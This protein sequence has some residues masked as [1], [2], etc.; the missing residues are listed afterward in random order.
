[1]S[2]FPFCILFSLFYFYTFILYVFYIYYYLYYR[3]CFFFLLGGGQHPHSSLH[4]VISQSAGQGLMPFMNGLIFN[5]DSIA[6]FP[7]PLWNLILFFLLFIVYYNIS[8]HTLSIPWWIRAW[9]IVWMIFAFCKVL[10]VWMPWVRYQRDNKEDIRLF[11]NS[12]NHV[13]LVLN[14]I[15]L[16]AFNV[17]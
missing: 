10:E 12:H 3:Y 17:T 7:N 16:C 9:R 15:A 8:S 5:L 11:Q 2:S 14:K 6:I 1:M 13:M 4:A